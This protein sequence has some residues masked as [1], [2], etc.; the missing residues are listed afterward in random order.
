MIDIF[1]VEV[2]RETLA[3]SILDALPE[4]FGIPTALAEYA[5]NAEGL[6]MLAARVDSPEPVGFLSL[7]RQTSVAAEAY[8]VG[9]RRELHRQGGADRC[10][11]LLNEDCSRTA[12]AT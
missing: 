12:F 8:V 9:V 3:R 4:W 11:R 5:R 7:R 2:G 6:P 1:N 10:L